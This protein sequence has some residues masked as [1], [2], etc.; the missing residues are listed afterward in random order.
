MGCSGSCETQ[1]S[2]CSSP[3][4]SVAIKHCGFGCRKKTEEVEKTPEQL[5]EIKSRVE[6][7]LW[8]KQQREDGKALG[9]L[10]PKDKKED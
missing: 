3:I 7:A 8:M 9:I 10:H 4:G 5:Q 1:E 6:Y 2:S